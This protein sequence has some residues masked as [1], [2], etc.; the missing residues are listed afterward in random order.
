[1]SRY[2]VV[3]FSGWRIMDASGRR[4]M[5][6]TDLHIVDERGRTVAVVAHEVS[7]NRPH[8]EMK[9]RRIADRLSGRLCTVKVGPWRWSYDCRRCRGAWSR[10]AAR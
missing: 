3:E 5:H 2:S 4:G 7:R 9:A 8:R 10:R 6:A 1:M